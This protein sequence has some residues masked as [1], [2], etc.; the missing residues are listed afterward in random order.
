MKKKNF[1]GIAVVLSVLMIVLMFTSM[2]FEVSA[3]Q[4][5]YTNFTSATYSSD[6][7][8]YMVNIATAQIGKTSSQLGYTEGWCDNFV[9]DCAIIAGQAAAIPQ[10][11]GVLDFL[12][13]LKSAG[14]YQVTSAQAGDVVVFYCNACG[15]WLHAALMTDST[16]CIS[17]NMNGGK[18]EK[19]IASWYRHECSGSGGAKI[20]ANIYYYRPLYSFAETCSYFKVHGDHNWSAGVCATCEY[21]LP[22]DH[23]LDESYA[24]TY[25]VAKNQTATFR[26]GPYEICTGIKA[27]TSG[28]FQIVGRVSNRASN[29]K[30]NYWYK[31]SDGYYVYHE[32]LEKVI[33]P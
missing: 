31:T 20:G 24:G 30:S 26:T 8:M 3:N 22:Y 28:T 10:G 11:G 15:K 33:I 23:D 21:S 27:V 25:K 18:V 2:T 19:H 9:S 13:N 17:G 16:N 32:R 5:K 14:A 1:K 29:A 6:P 4:S 7:C 12:N